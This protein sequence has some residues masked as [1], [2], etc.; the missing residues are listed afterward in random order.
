MRNMVIGALVGD[1]AALG[2]HWIY[3]KERVAA[4]GGDRPE[5]IEPDLANYKGGVGY[6]AAAGKTAGDSSHYGEQLQVALESLAATGGVLDASDYER[7]FVER[8]GPGG[9]WVGYIDYATRETLRNVDDAA[10]G[11]LE[12]ARSF[13]LGAHE[14]QRALFASKVTANASRWTG[15]KLDE[16]MAKAVRITHG[17]N[18]ELIGLAQGMAR[19][20]VEARRGFHGSDD[21]QLPAVSKLPAVVAYGADVDAAVRVTN[22]NDE[23]VA[24]AQ[25]IAGLLRGDIAPEDLAGEGGPACPLDQSVPVIGRILADADSFESGIRANILEGGDNAGRGVIIGA[26]LGAKFGVPP[27]WAQKT[28]AA[29]R[30][31]ALME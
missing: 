28:R 1:A 27:E 4:V 11:A 3:D 20:V 21:T 6:F 18:A 26:Y 15:A 22:N 2:L 25:K 14:E 24:W 19:A 17:D 29:A 5:F 16:A 12:A 9:A 13:D 7:R 23:A 31:N 10:R 8:F 30:W